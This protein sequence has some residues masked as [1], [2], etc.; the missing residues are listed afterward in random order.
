MTRRRATW[1]AS[2]GQSR[3]RRAGR[4]LRGGHIRVEVTAELYVAVVPAT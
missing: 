3:A 2:T 4:H 1:A